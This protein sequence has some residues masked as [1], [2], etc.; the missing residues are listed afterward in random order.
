[1]YRNECYVKGGIAESLGVLEKELRTESS[2][3]LQVSTAHKTG[4]SESIIYHLRSGIFNPEEE[5]SRITPQV[6]RTDT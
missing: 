6:I 1:M 5:S 4:P 2:L 3:C